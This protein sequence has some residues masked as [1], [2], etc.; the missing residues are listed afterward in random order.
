MRRFGEYAK[1]VDVAEAACPGVKQ[2]LLSGSF[3]PTR[4]E[5]CDL[6]KIPVEQVADRISEYRK[7]QEE[8]EEKRRQAREEMRRKADEEIETE[9]C[10]SS[11]GELSA[12]MA[13]PKRRNNVSNVL[14]IID[15]LAQRLQAICE[16]YIDEFPE[17]L[18]A[19][20]PR[21]LQAL[22]DL[23]EYINALFAD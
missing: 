3:K 21:L 5:V 20:K 9:K 7:A 1:G 14:G 23:K 10:F 17:L 8:R 15:D 2:E 18:A 11:I 22:N 6:A 12:F 4:Q 16:A 19:D 13:Q